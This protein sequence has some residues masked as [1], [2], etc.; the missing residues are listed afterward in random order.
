VR[1]VVRRAQ[2]AAQQLAG[3]PVHYV[4]GD[5][6]Q[7][8]TR[9]DAVRGVTTVVHLAA[10]AIERAGQS[11]EE[12]NTNMTAALI[13]AAR[14]AGVRRFVHMSQNGASSASP[15]RFLRS[16]GVA[17]EHVRASDL[18]WTVFRPSVIFGRGDEFVTVLAR[19]VRLSPVIYPLP[20]GGTARFQPVSVTDVA[21]AIAAAVRRPDTVR[22]SYPL[23]GP[24]A[25][26]LREM[27]E[28]I[29]GAMGTSRILVPVPVTVLRPIIAIAQRV[30]P[31]PPVTTALLGL[32]ALDNTVP[33]STAW[34]TLGVGSTPFT[35]GELAY[36][37]SI[38]VREAWTAMW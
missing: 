20:G 35:A 19:L 11:Y 1:V 7:A 38:T 4:V 18:D 21:H 30:F 9:S 16:K 8:A 37:R 23:G 27:I 10:I 2:R 14:A 13:E 3:I 36:L 33:D 26:T 28:R 6:R 29:L 24:E 25:L 31:R 34:A 32:L 12:V 17:E 22:Q 5:L 15:H